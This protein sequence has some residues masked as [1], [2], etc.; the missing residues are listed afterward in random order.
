MHVLSSHLQSLSVFIP[1]QTSVVF[2]NHFAFYF[3]IFHRYIKYSIYLPLLLTFIMF[4]GFSSVTNFYCGY[5]MPYSRCFWHYAS[6]N[7]DDL[8][9]YYFN[10]PWNDYY[11]HHP[12]QES[13]HSCRKHNGNY[14][15][16]HGDIDYSHF[17]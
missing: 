12:C 9:W 16:W 17:L 4:I 10:F 7:W 3:F 11:I 8:R 15:L 6:A 1:Y 5:L 14:C 13:I 2:C